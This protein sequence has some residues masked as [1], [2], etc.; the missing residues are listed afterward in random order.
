VGRWVLDGDVI[1]PHD[2]Q[3]IIERR[4]LQQNGIVTA[5][6]VI[7]KGGK[8]V[9]DAKIIVQGLPVEE[10]RDAFID[11]AVQVVE[12]AFYQA[13]DRDEAKLI[14]HIR[15][16]VRRLARDYTGKKPVTEISLIRL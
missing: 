9:A 6:L 12:K 10:D 1:I 13:A 7:G 5:T 4:R 3:T 2:G 16:A 15:I 8:L 14:E 11:E